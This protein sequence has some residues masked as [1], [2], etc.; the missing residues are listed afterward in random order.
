[1]WVEFST[2]QV[3]LSAGFD[4]VEASVPQVTTA[5]TLSPIDYVLEAVP[6]VS[7]AATDWVSGPVVSMEGTAPNIELQSVLTS[8]PFASAEIVAPQVVVEASTNETDLSVPQIQTSA[9]LLSGDVFNAALTAPQ[10][11]VEATASA[12]GQADAAVV[13]PQVSTQADLAP[14]RTAD[15]AFPVPAILVQATLS[16]GSAISAAFSAPNVEV[17]A[18]LFGPQAVDSALTAP[19]V[20]LVADMVAPVGAAERTVAM[21]THLAAV[22]E[23]SGWGFNSFVSFGGHVFAAS[24]GGIFELDASDADATAE[25]PAFFETGDVDFGD[26]RLKNVDRVYV[27]GVFGG[28]VEVDSILPGPVTRTY[29]VQ[30]EDSPRVATR[31]ARLGQRPL[32]TRWRFRFRNRFGK[33]FRVVRIIIRPSVK[34]RRVA[35]G[36]G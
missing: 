9:E 1:M 14:G 22:T 19:H 30:G 34:E 18:D 23:F 6:Q 21:N 28:D 26:S 35:N 12:A 33:N 13:V 29:L 11:L 5:G 3:S 20:V 10:I 16:Q 8:E 2:P 27:E 31:I 7:I 17:V 15:A 4:S 24:A 25:I 32:S 36:D